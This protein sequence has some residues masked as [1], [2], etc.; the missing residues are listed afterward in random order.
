MKRQAKS[1]ASSLE[2]RLSGYALAASA[3]GMGVLALAQPSEAKI[4]YTPTQVTIGRNGV[5]RLDL[6]RD[7]KVDFTVHDPASHLTSGNWKSLFAS[8]PAGNEIAGS[9]GKY[10][11]LASALERG[12]RISQSRKFAGRAMMAFNCSGSGCYPYSTRTSGNWVNVANRYLGLKFKIEGKVHYGWA[13]LSTQFAPFGTLS[14]VLTGYAYETIPNKPIVAGKTHG[15]DVVVEPASLG[16]LAR[17]ASA[18]PS[19]RGEQ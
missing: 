14:A 19:W 11:F 12:A 3:A 8:A 18:I 2:H 13:R 16:H 1:L 10:A 6:N 9:A 7:G 5:Y 17:G 4:V 15:K